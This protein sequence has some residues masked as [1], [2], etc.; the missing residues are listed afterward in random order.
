YAL[1]RNLTFAEVA[2]IETRATSLSKSNYKVKDI[3]KLIINSDF[4]LKK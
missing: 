4:F 1:K 3:V 2:E